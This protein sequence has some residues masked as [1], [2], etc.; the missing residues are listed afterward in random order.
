MHG[1]GIAK[2]LQKALG[3]CR[4][5]AETGS[6]PAELQMGQFYLHG[7]ESIQDIQN[8]ASWLEQAAHK[9]SL[10][11]SFQL[12]ITN[13]SF[14]NDPK[15]ALYWFETA[16][17]QGYTPAYY[18]TAKLYFEAPVSDETGLPTEDNLA[19]AYLWLS[20]TKAQPTIEDELKN[21]I[22]MLEKSKKSCLKAGH[23]Y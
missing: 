3:Y 6:I 11:A 1:K 15:H 21:A 18:P 7:D 8:A 5:V 10:E 17:S 12:G 9:G 16:A 19:K 13:L 20:A 14:A 23:L 2:D 22:E 4:Q